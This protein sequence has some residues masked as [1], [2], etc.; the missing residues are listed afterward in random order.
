MLTGPWR[1][2]RRPLRRENLTATP[3]QGGIALD[4]ADNSEP[5]LAGYNV[6]R[7]IVGETE[8]TRLN[9]ELLNASEYKDTKAPGGKTSYYRVTAVDKVGNES[10][11]AADSAYRT[12]IDAPLASPESADFGNVAVGKTTTKDVNLKNPGGKS[13]G[14]MVINS[15]EVKGDSAFATNFRG[16]IT[17]APGETKVVKVSFAPRSTGLKKADLVIKHDRSGK[18]LVVSLSGTGTAKPGACTIIGTNGND[19]LRG[20][21]GDDVICGLGGDDK[22]YGFN[23]NDTLKGG[24]GKNRLVGGNGNDTLIG[25]NDVD[26]A[27]GQNGDDRVFGL[28]GNDTLKGGSGTNRIAG[29]NGNDR[30]IGGNNVDIIFGQNGNDVLLGL[31]GNDRMAGGNGGDRIYGQNGNDTLV[32]QGGNDALVGGRGRDRLFGNTGRDFLNGR[33]GVRGND[34]LNGGSD[35]DR[36][37]ADPRDRIVG[38]P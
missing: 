19:T 32:G 6:S 27:Y 9:T 31:G 3:S 36:S 7:R 17:L 28:D 2:Q 1:I 13:D 30:I 24:P 29:G 23:G 38:I 4:W 34:Y 10:N 12:E 22:I 20:T 18:D 21:N 8:F 26:E 14:P 37:I 25:G 15:G 16:P 11:F 33:D 5:D 35:R